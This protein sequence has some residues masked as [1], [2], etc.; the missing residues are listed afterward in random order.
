MGSGRLLSQ[1]GLPRSAVGCQ[2]EAEA[3]EPGAH[4]QSMKSS[5]PHPGPLPRR[6]VWTGERGMKGSGPVVNG[7][8]VR[9]QGSGV[10]FWVLSSGFW[11]DAKRG[12]DG[13]GT[14]VPPVVFFAPQEKP[15]GAGVP[16]RRRSRLG[17]QV[18][19]VRCRGEVLGFEQGW[20]I[21]GGSIWH[22][23]VKTWTTE[24]GFL[25]PPAVFRLKGG[26]GLLSWP[27]WLSCK[28]DFS[29]RYRER[30]LSP[31]R[32][33]LPSLSRDAKCLASI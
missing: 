31:A 10:R 30:K 33:A 8:G 11:M 20:G 18:P 32:S 17:D 14:G 9:G 29:P 27:A 13:G 15:G 25:R 1:H 5:L 19:G 12:K 16:A 23:S 3:H 21:P 24:N 4:P 28:G 26:G 7:L 22:L 6:G 2:A